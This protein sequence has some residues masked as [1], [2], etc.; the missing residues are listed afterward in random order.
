M[1]IGHTKFGPV[2]TF[3]AHERPPHYVCASCIMQVG[4]PQ[5]DETYCST[6]RVEIEKEAR[7][8]RSTWLRRCETARA[9]LREIERLFPGHLDAHSWTYLH[10]D[11]QDQDQLEDA[12]IAQEEARREVRP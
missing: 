4:C 9:E 1:I 3:R 5:D 10:E 7:G 2:Q 6:C 8:N 12:A 11:G